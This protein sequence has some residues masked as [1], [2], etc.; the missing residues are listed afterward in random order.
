MRI[1]KIMEILIFQEIRFGEVLYNGTIINQDKLK[2]FSHSN[3]NGHEE[4]KEYKF[5]S[6]DALNDIKTSEN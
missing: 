2:L 4:T 6:F 5:I 1:M 3:I